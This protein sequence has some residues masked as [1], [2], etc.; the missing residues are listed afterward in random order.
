MHKEAYLLGS[1]NNLFCGSEKA[2]KNTFFDLLSDRGT[3]WMNGHRSVKYI[4][5]IFKK[6]HWRKT[7]YVSL[8]PMSIVK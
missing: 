6:T 2:T 5:D 3:R 4:A 8:L 7:D 1:E